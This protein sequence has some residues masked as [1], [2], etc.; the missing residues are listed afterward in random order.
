M[1]GGDRLQLDNDT[2]IVWLGSVYQ[3]P[4]REGV[5]NNEYMVVQ[6]KKYDSRRGLFFGG[7]LTD[8]CACHS[9]FMDDGKGDYDLRCKA[10]HNKVP[11]GQGDGSEHITDVIP[12]VTVITWKHALSLEVKGLRMTRG[13]S[14]YAIVKEKMGFKGSKQK[15]YEQVV[16]LFDNLEHYTTYRGNKVRVV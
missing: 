12:M 11:V 14:V 3:R 2:S 10:C 4:E 8:C 13:R 9:T 1:Q 6:G 5:M 7:R 16:T 15:V